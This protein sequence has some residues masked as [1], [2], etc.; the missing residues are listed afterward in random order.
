ME[1]GSRATHYGQF[2]KNKASESNWD[3]LSEQLLTVHHWTAGEVNSTV[4]LSYIQV[5]TEMR[6]LDPSTISDLFPWQ[7]GL[8]SSP[9]SDLLT[10]PHWASEAS[11]EVWDL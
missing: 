6:E 10:T 5:C 8:P 2:W 7:Q 3:K 9:V 4:D 11:L 1:R